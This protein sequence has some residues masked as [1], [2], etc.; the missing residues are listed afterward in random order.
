MLFPFV[1]NFLMILK[2]D[3]EELNLALK[4]KVEG[5]EYVIFATMETMKCFKCG[6]TS[7]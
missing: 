7:S 6:E 5:F 4:C 2:G 3:V 1:D